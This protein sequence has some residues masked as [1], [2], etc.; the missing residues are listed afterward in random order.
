MRSTFTSLTLAIAALAAASSAQAQQY[1]IYG[2]ANLDFEKTELRGTPA[3]EAFSGN[4]RVS[5]NSSR[6]GVRASTQFEGLTVFAQVESG[7]SWDAGGDTLAGRDTFAG[8]EGTF[9]KIR[10]GKMDTP[11]KDLGGLTDRFKGTGIQDDGG[12]AMLG[13]SSNG[14]G[15]RQSN[16]LRYDTPDFAGFG[17]SLQ[18]GLDN[19]DKGSAEQKK[20]LSLSLNYRLD[21]LKASLAVEQHRN[22]NE[23]GFKDHAWRIGANYDFGFLNVGAGY[24]ELTYKLAAGT[25]KRKYAAVSAAVPVGPKG[26]ISVRFSKAGAVNGSAP[27]GTTIAGADG[28]QLFRGADSGA[29]YYMLGYEHTIFKGA[30]LYTY[31]TRIDNQANAN[32]RF[33]VNPLNVTAADRGA[34]P[35]GIVVGILYDF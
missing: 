33:G 31:W 1:T 6:L 28:N 24:N 15:R 13:G 2:R 16:S 18:Y 17:A 8:L 11:M 10:I 30:Q 25:L 23:P 7:V 20:L 14:F 35:S 4:Q 12:I 27:E 26:A 29:R 5:S 21:K 9:G 19:E 34:D 32:Y 22:F 3:A